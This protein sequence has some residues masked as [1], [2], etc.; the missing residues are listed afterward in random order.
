MDLN[1]WSAF[2]CCKAVIEPMIAQRQGCIVNISSRVFLDGRA[3]L[4]V[5]SSAKAGLVAL[6]QCLALEFGQHGIRV[7]AVAPGLMLPASREQVGETSTKFRAR[8]K[9][10]DYDASARDVASQGRLAH[11]DDVARIVT[12]LVSD[13][14]ARFITGKVIIADGGTT[15]GDEEE[16]L[17]ATQRVWAP[18]EARK[19]D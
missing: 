9:V 19:V 10:V 12:F 11:P 18:A 15:F 1:Y 8:S 7:N 13:D 5:Y 4:P 6:T 14:A 17:A 3:D 2:Y 16:G